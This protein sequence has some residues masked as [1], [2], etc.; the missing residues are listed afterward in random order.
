MDGIQKAYSS[1]SDLFLWTK[2]ESSDSLSLADVPAV[3]SSVHPFIIDN[4]HSIKENILISSSEAI[5]ASDISKE[6]K[7]FDEYVKVFQTR[8]SQKINVN[9]LLAKYF[10]LLS[11]MLVNDYSLSPRD[12]DTVSSE[13]DRVSSFNKKDFIQMR[14]NLIIGADLIAD[15]IGG[16]DDSYNEIYGR[17][18]IAISQT[19]DIAAISSIYQFR[20]AIKLIESV[21]ANEQVLKSDSLLDP[22][23]YARQ[24]SNNPNFDVGSYTSGKLVK[25][26]Y[27]ESLQTLALRTMGSEDRWYDIA[28]ANG[29]KSPYIDEVGYAVPMLSNA[30][31][32]QINI[33]AM[34]GSKFTKDMFFVNQ[35]IILQ[36]D[37]ESLPDQRIITA[38]KVVPI[39]GDLVIEVDGASNLDKYT[40][41]DN[42]YVRVYEK[43]TVNSS[44]Y[45]LIPGDEP[46]TSSP[47]ET[48]WFLKSSAEDEKR[49]GIDLGLSDSGDLL[50]T[51]TGDIQM[52]YG[53][54]NAIQC[55]KIMMSTVQGSLRRHPD[56][57]IIETIGK[58]NSDVTKIRSS[59]AESVATLILNDGRFDR[60][61]YLTVE[62][63]ND[64]GM[65]GYMI[66]LGVVLSGGGNNV[67][68][69]SFSI[70]AP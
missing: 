25:L 48:P 22:F 29:L 12:I 36:S 68:P 66:K 62:Y 7:M 67:I 60:L 4:W 41:L 24:L 23:A 51:S 16:G 38:I 57:G 8:P 50:F 26:N 61:D 43:Y 21:L 27:G 28:I 39:S 13:Q 40:T 3:I 45:V 17:S 33:A 53:V 9:S 30:S 44:L 52:S 58:Q 35:I 55:L 31:G 65:S 20:T 2:V 6:A 32:N 49:A 5:N 69:I 11:E 15:R 70:P 1:L 64:S 56:F 42:A 59:I 14:E 37:I 46:V 19:K 54:D 10:N 63:S 34:F 18:S 47:K